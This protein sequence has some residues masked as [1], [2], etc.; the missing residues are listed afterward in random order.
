MGFGL[1]V[2]FQLTTL[3]PAINASNTPLYTDVR[4]PFIVA[5]SLVGWALAFLAMGWIAVVVSRRLK[6]HTP[7][8]R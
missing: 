4:F 7:A 3:D 2:A 8:I 6:P 5:G 1:F